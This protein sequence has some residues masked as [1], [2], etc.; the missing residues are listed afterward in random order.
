MSGSIEK[1]RAASSAL[2]AFDRVRSLI[3]KRYGGGGGGGGVGSIVKAH[4]AIEIYH[5]E[6]DGARNY[7][8]VGCGNEHVKAAVDA[9]AREFAPAILARARE[10][11]AEKLKDA[12]TLARSE[13]AAIVAVA[14]EIECDRCDGT[15]RHGANLDGADVEVFCGE[16]PLGLRSED[17]YLES[18]G[19]GRINGTKREVAS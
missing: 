7:H 13:A 17:D 11:L 5:Q 1:F 12:A 3:G 19:F 2:L 10:L 16:C 9:A 14:G 4:A 15:G 6:Y 18:Q 8:D